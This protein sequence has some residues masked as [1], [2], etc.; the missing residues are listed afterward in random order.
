M[1]K[2]IYK[3]KLVE[4]ISGSSSED[5]REKID[6]LQILMSYYKCAMHE[7]EAKFKVLNEQFS[8]QH[9]RNPIELIKT[10]LKT[11]ESISEKLRRKELPLTLISIEE[12]LILTTWQE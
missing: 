4:F 1:E 9:E 3:E 6:S 12:N 11:I 10:R 8:L 5:L 2:E 7:I